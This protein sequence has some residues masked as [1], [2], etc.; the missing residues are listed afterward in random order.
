MNRMFPLLSRVDWTLVGAYLF[1][2]GIGLV[3][4]YS[5]SLS[6]GDGSYFWKQIGF[7]VAGAVIVSVTA[8]IPHTL[9]ARRQKA[10]TIT[11]VITLVAVLLFGKTIRGTTGWFSIGGFGIQPVE[12]VKVLMVLVL[13]GFFAVRAKTTSGIMLIIQSGALVAV[14]AGLVL[15]QPDFGSASLLVLIWFGLLIVAGVKKRYLLAIALGFIAL[16]V[17]AWFFL[18]KPYQKDRIMVFWDPGRDPLGRG[19]NVTQSV[20]AIGSGGFFGKGVGY[21]SQSQLRFLPERQTDFIF[22][23]I[24]EELG[25]VGVLV[26]MSLFSVMIFRFYKIVSESDDSFT[27]YMVSGFALAV[28]LE[29]FINIGSNIRL[30]PVTGVTLPFMSYGGSSLLAKSLMIGLVQSAA[31][32]VHKLR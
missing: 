23:V 16:A 4:L 17:V 7:T 24:A 14:L 10:L 5:A 21:G 2:I 25:F 31:I 20:I 11:A 19:Y 29:T 13:A 3:S 1:L 12:L 15:L 22:A 26:V 9:F 8:L 18:L 27:I 28:T 32:H 30:L 6:D